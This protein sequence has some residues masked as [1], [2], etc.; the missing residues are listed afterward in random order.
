MFAATARNQAEYSSGGTGVN[1]LSGSYSRWLATPL[2]LMGQDQ[3]HHVEIPLA[4]IGMRFDV[5]EVTTI[6]REDRSDVRSDRAEPGRVLFRRYGCEPA[7][8]VVFALAGVWRRRDDDVGAGAIEQTV[9]YVAVA[10]ITAD[11]FVPG[12]CPNVAGARNRLS[13]SFGNLLFGILAGLAAVVG[14]GKQHGQLVIAEAQCSPV[15]VSV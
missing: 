10:A 4:V 12:N 14:I 11:D 5:Q 3:I 9:H 13:R 8:R 6:R 7:L 15:N 1:P 2:P